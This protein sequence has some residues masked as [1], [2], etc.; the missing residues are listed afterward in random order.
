MIRLELVR[1]EEARNL[2]WLPL[3][4]VLDRV[5]GAGGYGGDLSRTFVLWRS[6]AMV[7]P[8]IQ[9]LRGWLDGRRS[10]LWPPEL[11]EF[12]TDGLTLR[13]HAHLR[14]QRHNVRGQR[15]ARSHA[16]LRVLLW[17]HG[18]DYP[19]ALIQGSIIH[20]IQQARK[21]AFQ[22]NATPLEFLRWFF[23]S[24]RAFSM[25]QISSRRRRTSRDDERERALEVFEKWAGVLTWAEFD[26]AQKLTRVDL[27]RPRSL[28]EIA[29]AV[30]LADQRLF[31]VARMQAG[32]IVHAVFPADQRGHDPDGVAGSYESGQPPSDSDWIAWEGLKP[33]IQ[34]VPKILRYLGLLIGWQIAVLYEASRLPGLSIVA[35]TDT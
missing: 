16:A 12:L 17:A 23:L 19:L 27:S 10:V 11:V 29:Q 14:G 26:L 9:P 5:A 18:W 15:V 20:V 3:R 4:E 31:D 34:Q 25:S 32:R 21:V 24:S 28:R 2:G 1:L 35:Q 6:R 13:V 8:T 33:V 7:P 22:Q 30:H